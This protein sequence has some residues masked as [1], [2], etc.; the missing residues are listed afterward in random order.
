VAWQ[1]EH[2][3]RRRGGIPAST[4]KRSR[5]PQP[6]QLTLKDDG[7]SGKLWFILDRSERRDER[8]PRAAGSPESLPVVGI[9]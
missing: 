5:V 3:I 4:V 6:G 7:D 8:A 2:W 1:E 9:Q